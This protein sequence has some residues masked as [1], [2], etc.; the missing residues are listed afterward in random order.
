MPREERNEK[1]PRMTVVSMEDEEKEGKAKNCILHSFLLWI[2]L[3]T[4]ERHTTRLRLPY[5]S[6]TNSCTEK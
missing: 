4:R 6:P 5:N 2:F 3:V 1:Q